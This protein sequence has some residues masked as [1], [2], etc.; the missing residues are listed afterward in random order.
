MEEKKKQLRVTSP[1]TLE[2]RLLR[3]GSSLQFV[4]DPTLASSN[5]IHSNL[6]T[7]HNHEPRVSS[8]SRLFLRFPSAPSVR[9]SS[10]PI[11]SSLTF[12]PRVFPD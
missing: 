5:H 9:S 10:P 2:A 4:I 11:K 7:E 3:G 12:N 8:A 1:P 6:F